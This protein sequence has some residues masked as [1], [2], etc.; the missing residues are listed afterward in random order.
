MATHHDAFRILWE[1]VHCF[2]DKRVE[3]IKKSEHNSEESLLDAKVRNF[4]TNAA[5]IPFAE[6]Y[7]TLSPHISS[8]L[9]E[10]LFAE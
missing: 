1:R 10:E 2:R 8:Q 9:S 6:V 7:P 4:L 3:A 5:L